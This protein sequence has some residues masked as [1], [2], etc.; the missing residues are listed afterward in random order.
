[1]KTKYL[2]PV[3][4]VLLVALSY[5]GNYRASERELCERANLLFLQEHAGWGDSLMRIM[6]I[7][8]WGRYDSEAYRKKKKH[9]LL[10]LQD[11]IVISTRFYHPEYTKYLRDVYTCIQLL[12]TMWGEK[13]GYELSIVDSLFQCALVREGIEAEVVMA[14]GIRDL[15]KIFPTEDS[16]CVDVPIEYC[17]VSRELADGV[18]LDTV[19]IGICNQ[20]ELS[21][22]IRLQPSVVRAHMSLFG[23]NQVFAIVVFLFVGMLV[24]LFEKIRSVVRS[25]VIIGNT[26]IDLERGVVCLW[27]GECR[28]INTNQLVLLKMLIAATPAYKLRKEEIC[29]TL[30]GRNAKDGQ[31]LYNTTVSSLRKLFVADDE[32]LELKTLSKEG[33]ELIVSPSLLKKRQMLHFFIQFSLSKRKTKRYRNS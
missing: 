9:T 12:E 3:L 18:P 2:L 8:T 28:S 1:M 21:A 20:G 27:D 24:Y 33:I 4:L 31:A 5:M 17:E 22:A 19:N 26:A 32:S 23:W 14:L 29:Q 10:S 15:G 11:T 25:M 13:D 16:M 6:K 7:P 30:W